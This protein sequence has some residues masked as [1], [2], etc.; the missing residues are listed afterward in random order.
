[1]SGHTAPRC[2]VTNST[3]PAA[4]TAASSATASPPR[5]EV[6]L[7]G[8]PGKPSMPTPTAD[9]HTCSGHRTLK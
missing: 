1:M 8:P 6:A 3:F 7:G 2:R 9:G 4:V 5:P